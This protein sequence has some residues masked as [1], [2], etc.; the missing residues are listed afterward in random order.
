MLESHQRTKCQLREVHITLSLPSYPFPFLDQLKVG[1]MTQQNLKAKFY[2]PLK[3]DFRIQKG[4]LV[5]YLPLILLFYNLGRSNERRVVVVQL[6]YGSKT[7]VASLLFLNNGC[8]MGEGDLGVV[9]LGPRGYME[10][11]AT[12]PPPCLFLIRKVVL[13]GTF[14]V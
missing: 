5:I 11:T 1:D 7:Q 14:C 10:G 8:P 3:V 2:A 12:L 13:Q 9:A 4:S 6:M